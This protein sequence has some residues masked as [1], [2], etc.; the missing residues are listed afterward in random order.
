MKLTHLLKGKT[1]KVVSA[2]F[3]DS[4]I[5]HK[6]N[7]IGITKNTII[8]V[9]D[10]DNN[11]RLLHLLIYGVEYVLRERDCRSINVSEYQDNKQF[12]IRQ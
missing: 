10:Y 8:D 4:H 12:A 1:I 3:K 5:L 9:L 7:N 6:I 2:N 11:N